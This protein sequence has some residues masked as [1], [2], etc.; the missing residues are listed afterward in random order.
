[1]GDEDELNTGLLLFI[2]HRAMEARVF[3]ELAEA[4]FDDFTPAQARVRRR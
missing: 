3:R 2:P 1:M 4:G